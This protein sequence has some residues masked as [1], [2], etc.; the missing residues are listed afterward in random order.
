MLSTQLAFGFSGRQALNTASIFAR[1][2]VYSE[3]MV[4]FYTIKT[5]G[6]RPLA[7]IQALL[8]G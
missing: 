7:K 6:E 3:S 4:L 8:K 5:P 2:R 1:R